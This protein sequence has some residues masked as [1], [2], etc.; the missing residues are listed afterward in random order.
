M[1]FKT[2]GWRIHCF[3]PMAGV[4]A[5]VL[6]ADC[7]RVAQRPMDPRP[8]RPHTHALELPAAARPNGLPRCMLLLQPTAVRSGVSDQAGDGGRA[9]RIR[10][11]A[12]AATA[13]HHALHGWWRFGLRSTG[14]SSASA[15]FPHEPPLHGFCKRRRLL[16]WRRGRRGTT[17]GAGQ[18]RPERPSR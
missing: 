8:V 13:P 17:E 16:C 12:R 3:V 2:F 14:I 5:P 15:W 10:R 1:S 7:A 6:D 18:G 4:C 11:L 9:D